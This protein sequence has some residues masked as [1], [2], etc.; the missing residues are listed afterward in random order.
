MI[1]IMIVEDDLEIAQ[2]EA[3]ALKYAGFDPTVLESIPDALKPEPWRDIQVGLI[4]LMLPDVQGD[5]ILKYLK[6]NQAQVKRV[7]V[8][9]ATDAPQAVKDLADIVLFKP[10]SLKQ[11]RQVCE[12]GV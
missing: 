7:L 9:A 2:M 5:V 8:T 4:D 3:A 1:R 11:L 10:Y 6:E 12:P